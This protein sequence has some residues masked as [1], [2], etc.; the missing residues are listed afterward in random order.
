LEDNNIGLYTTTVNSIYANHIVCQ[1]CEFSSN[2]LLGVDFN[3]GSNFKLLGCDIESN[4][5]AGNTATGGVMINNN[6]D[7]EI[8]FATVTLNNCWFEANYGRALQTEAHGSIQEVF[9]TV[10]N[11]TFLSSENGNAVYIS[12]IE[13]LVFFN[14]HAPTAA[15]DTVDVVDCEKTFFMNCRIIKLNDSSN[16]PTWYNVDQAA[17]GLDNDGFTSD[18]NIANGKGLQF[19]WSNGVGQHKFVQ[20]TNAGMLNLDTYNTTPFGIRDRLNVGNTTTSI[21]SCKVLLVDSVGSVGLVMQPFKNGTGKTRWW[22]VADIAT[23]FLKIGGE[24]NT[25]PTNYKLEIGPDVSN[26]MNINTRAYIDT[27]NLGGNRPVVP[28]AGDMYYFG[29]HVSPDTL[30]IYNGTN[31][32]NVQLTW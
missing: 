31:W 23:S 30:R 10:E 11:T 8:G 26:Y 2:D 18:V 9:L 22:I 12:D 15:G 13:K 21:D 5:T 7:D 16:D 25:K 24:G 28:A 14:S 3:S 17:A 6:I 1:D 19:E 32:M 27:V 4:G 29:N 20:N